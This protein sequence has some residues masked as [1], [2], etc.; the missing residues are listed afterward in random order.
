MSLLSDLN[1]KIKALSTRVGTEVKSLWSG[2][3]TAQST[4]TAAQTTANTANSTAN[5][6]KSTADTANSTANTALSTANAKVSKAGDMM[7]GNLVVAKGFPQARL[8]DTRLSKGTLPE[9]TMYMESFLED[10]SGLA[11]NDYTST[12]HPSTMNIGIFGSSVSATGIVQTYLRAYKYEADSTASHT[13]GVEYDTANSTGYAFTTATK[14]RFGN[15]TQFWI[16]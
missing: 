9:T 6:A 11:V 13:I 8:I 15:G 4:A 2:V 14:F 7:T 10:S 5:T 12:E 16:A 1:N 3:N